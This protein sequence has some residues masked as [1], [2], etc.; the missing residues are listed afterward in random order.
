MDKRKKRLIIIGILSLILT[1][2]AYE[3][4][5]IFNSNAKIDPL[6][7]YIVALA[8]LLFIVLSALLNFLLVRINK[9]KF[10]KMRVTRIYDL[11]DSMREK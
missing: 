3:A 4:G 11:L 10:K 9:N 8:S 6:P 5:F 7:A 1:F 2:A